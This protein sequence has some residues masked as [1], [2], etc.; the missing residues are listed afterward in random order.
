MLAAY[1]CNWFHSLEECANTFV[2]IVKTFE[3]IQENVKAYEKLFDIYQDVYSSTKELNNQL[4]EFR[5]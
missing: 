2:Q 4:R 5:K 1:G 3:P